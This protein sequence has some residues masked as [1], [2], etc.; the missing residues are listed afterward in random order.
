RAVLQLAAQHLEQLGL[1][2][3]DDD[4][5]M[6]VAAPGAVAPSLRDDGPH[7]PGDGP[8]GHLTEES[9]YGRPR[10][11]AA[12]G[13]RVGTDLEADFAVGAQRDPR[14]R[15]V[16]PGCRHM[17]ARAHGAPKWQARCHARWPRHLIGS[18][19]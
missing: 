10:G 12:R 2:A 7:R 19:L 4:E 11:T 13:A 1:L 6:R 18:A 14:E 3:R 9:G 16:H 5:V 15:E 17:E 8:V